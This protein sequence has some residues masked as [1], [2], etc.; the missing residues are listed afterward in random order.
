MRARPEMA[1]KQSAGGQAEERKL[2]EEEAR[3][4]MESK[5]IVESSHPDLRAMKDVVVILCVCVC[6]G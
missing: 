6:N 3:S 4:A 1:R 2:E 5:K